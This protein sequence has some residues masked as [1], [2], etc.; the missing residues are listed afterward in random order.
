MFIEPCIFLLSFEIIVMGMKIHTC[1]DTYKGVYTSDDVIGSAG[2]ML[3]E[4][5]IYNPHLGLRS[6][7]IM[8]DFV[9][10]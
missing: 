2:Y 6:L 5:Q 7:G 3:N 4:V 9:F 1:T 10:N 8:G